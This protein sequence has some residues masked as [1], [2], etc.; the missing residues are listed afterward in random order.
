MKLRWLCFAVFLALAGCKPAAESRLEAIIGAELINGTGGPPISRSIVIVAGTRFRA[1]GDQPNTPVPAGSDKVN[2]AG[3]FIVPAF[4]E[5]PPNANLPVVSTV[6]EVNTEVEAGAQGLLGMITDSEEIDPDLINRLR[7]L[8]IVMF[9]RL[10]RLAGDKLDR[11]QRNTKRLA[12]AGVLIGV[13]G[14]PSGM[15]ECELLAEAGL[16]PMDIIV[17]AT[18]NAAMALKQQD[19]T[20]TIAPG[21]E[22]NLLL[23]RANP[24]E[25]V[26][27]LAKVERKMLRGEWVEPA[28]RAA[29]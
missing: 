24:L 29:R 18:R 15:W 12:A 26:R 5:I 8:R 11:A 16:T 4:I 9:P 22:A 3:R 17:A 20:G 27:N 10:N 19:E 21:K 14:G 1:V 13:D 2:G 23:L 28:P 6:E 7:D 25:D